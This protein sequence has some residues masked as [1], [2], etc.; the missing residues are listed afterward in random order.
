MLS[1]THQ[2]HPSERA[3]WTDIAVEVSMFT[4][5]LCKVMSMLE[6]HLPWLLS[7]LSC[8]GS[9]RMLSCGT[10]MH[11]CSSSGKVPDLSQRTSVRQCTQ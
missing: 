8:L 10:C 1:R 3:A 6:E 9:V 2:A 7:F 11:N 5:R 4:A